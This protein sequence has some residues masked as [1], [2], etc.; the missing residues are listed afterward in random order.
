MSELYSLERVAR[1]LKLPVSRL[2]S[3]DRSGFLKPS[4]REGRKRMYT[5]RDMVELRA[6][7]ELLESGVTLR[8]VRRGLDAL[9]QQLPQGGEGLGASRVRPDGRRVV[10][11]DARA[12]FEPET[13]QLVLD[14]AVPSV[15]EQVLRT[16]APRGPKSAQEWY[17]L[18]CRLDEDEST[19]D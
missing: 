1:I 5:F 11:Q 14:F 4:G 13:G 6:A 12:A 10:A 16:L 15:S 19:L 18:G 17:L 2:R 9:R 8:R 7:K 3:W